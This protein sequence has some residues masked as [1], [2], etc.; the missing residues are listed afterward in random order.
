MKPRSPSCRPPTKKPTC[1]RHKGKG[2][3]NAPLF[4]MN[5]VPTALYCITSS[6]TPTKYYFGITRRPVT[7]LREHKVK[8]RGGST[9][10]LARAIR[11]R[12]ESTFRMHVLKWFPSRAKA[13]DAEREIISAYGGPSSPFLWNGTN[14]GDAGFGYDGETLERI[15]RA[16][17]I[18][19]MM[20]E[21]KIRRSA[22]S[23]VAWEEKTDRLL[24]SEAVKASITREVIERRTAS[25]LKTR[26]S[27]SSLLRNS[28]FIRGRNS[29]EPGDCVVYFGV[30]EA[31]RDGFDESGIYKVLNGKASLCGGFFWEKIP[32][33]DGFAARPDLFEELINCPAF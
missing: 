29:K 26:R 33:H 12:G 8:A 4:K 24:H 28:F 16:Q 31:M 14:G 30:R 1:S 6:T 7:R 32:N 27:V 18:S 3:R 17:R 13:A 5:D 25:F 15:K 21:A 11:K 19:F 2:R 23:K 9:S 10:K 22:A 20:P